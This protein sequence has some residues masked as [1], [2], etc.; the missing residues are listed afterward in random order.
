MIRRCQWASSLISCDLPSSGAGSAGEVIVTVHQQKRNT[1]YL[2]LWLGTFTHTV[3]ERDTLKQ[4]ATYNVTLRADIRKVRYEIHK[5]PTFYRFG[6]ESPRIV[7][8]TDTSLLGYECSGSAPAG[9]DN[10]TET[11]SGSGTVP[12]LR[13]SPLQQ[14]FL[15]AGG[16]YDNGRLVLAFSPGSTGR[17]VTIACD[18][19]TSMENKDLISVV[20]APADGGSNP[21][22]SLDGSGNIIGKTLTFKDGT[23]AHTFKW[24]DIQIQYPPSP[25][26]PR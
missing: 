18:S 23:E 4:V 21:N 26:S 12:R 22:L 7:M 14:G 8:A 2:S 9:G 3:T 1:A 24:S 15:V 6:I 11:W 13:T 10:C 17:K 19:G 16:L 25:T 5:E 20:V